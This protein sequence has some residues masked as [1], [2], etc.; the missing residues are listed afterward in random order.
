MYHTT[1]QSNIKPRSA[2]VIWKKKNIVSNFSI[3]VFESD[4]G[5]KWARRNLYRMLLFLSIL[6]SKTHFKR[7][8]NWL[9]KIFQI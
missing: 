5:D 3:P 6:M 2:K 7:L 1:L 9:E 4:W 8:F